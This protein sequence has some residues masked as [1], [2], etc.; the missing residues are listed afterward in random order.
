MFPDKVSIPVPMPFTFKGLLPEIAQEIV[1]PPELS[2]L[3]ILFVELFNSKPNVLL[4]P[5]AMV[6]NAVLLFLIITFSIP[7]TIAPTINKVFDAVP[8]LLLIVLAMAP[9]TNSIAATLRWG[10]VAPFM[11]KPMVVCAALPIR[12]TTVEL[13]KPEF[14]FPDVNQAE[15]PPFHKVVEEFTKFGVALDSVPLLQ[16]LPRLVK[17]RTK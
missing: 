4:D 15:L 7:F 1:I 12:A 17:I 13:G 11:L 10:M 5:S 8:E 16:T 3:M 14:Q 9:G 6:I 2:I